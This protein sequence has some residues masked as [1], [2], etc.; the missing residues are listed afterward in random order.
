M[1]R[2]SVVIADDHGAM[3]SMVECA[4]ADT[5]DVLASVASGPEAVRAAVEHQPD[6]CLLDVEMPGGDGVE[7]AREIT[8]RLP[9]TKCVMFS[10]ATD[11]ERLLS[12][13]RA[14]AVGYLTK[15]MDLDRLPMALLG[16][17]HSEA[18]VPRARVTRVIEELRSLHPAARDGHR[19]I[20][21]TDEEWQVIQD[22]RA[23]A[24]ARHRAG[25]RW[26]SRS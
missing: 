23:G 7:A 21:V 8:A 19:T 15:D 18:A 10:A 17:L 24:P 11:D 13:L 3:R 25:R 6:V 5:C 12:A 22:L 14:G 9:A 1:A 4:L 2:I 20:D 16:T 26:L